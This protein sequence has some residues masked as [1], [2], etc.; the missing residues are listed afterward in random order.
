MTLK[1]EEGPS[2][3][4]G[5]PSISPV[6]PLLLPLPSPLLRRVLVIVVRF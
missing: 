4:A 1:P 3:A 5:L 2:T 6:G